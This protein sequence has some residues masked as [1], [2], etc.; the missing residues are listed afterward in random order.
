M[1]D[2]RDNAGELISQRG[3]EV[4]A[5]LTEL[6]TV[7]TEEESFGATLDRVVELALH[8]I[9]GCTAAS[10]TVL[11]GSGAA[12]TRAATDD[13]MRE[14]DRQQYDVDD[15]PCLDAARNQTTNRCDLAEAAERWPKFTSLALGYGMRSYLSVGL[16]VA[17]RPVGALNL[18]SADVDGFDALD[19]AF[20]VLFSSPATATIIGM[21]RYAEAR[22]LAAQLEQA[23]ESRAV[24]DHAIGVI[25]AQSQCG[26]EQAFSILRRASNNRNIKLRD[27]ATEIVSRYDNNGAGNG[28]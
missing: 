2:T 13:R 25:M 1:T 6:A 27:L 11:D 23:L 19:E 10:V 21:R 15:G 9:P 5:A 3:D 20:L 26:T 8:A 7:L 18:A 28:G 4:V 17:G 12:A 22:A 14:V 24:I 16:G